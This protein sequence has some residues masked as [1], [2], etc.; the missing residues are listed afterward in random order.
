[1][2]G[3]VGSSSRSLALGLLA[4]LFL[5]NI[6]YV[7]SAR[8]TLV[9]AVV[10]LLLFVCQRFGWRQAIGIV[11]LATVA[12]VLTWMSSPYLRTRVLDVVH[13]IQDYRTKGGGHVLRLSSRVLDPFDRDRLAGADP[14]ARHWISA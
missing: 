7:A 2:R 10:L 3:N 13:E 9:A 5:A 1:M 14:R 11:T 6:A 12:G 8:S 4:L